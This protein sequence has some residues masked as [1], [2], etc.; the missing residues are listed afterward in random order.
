MRRYI[1]LEVLKGC[2]EMIRFCWVWRLKNLEWFAVLHY[3]Y[4]YFHITGSNKLNFLIFIRQA[5]PNTLLR[6]TSSHFR[7]Y[8]R[9]VSSNPAASFH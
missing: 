1:Y 2:L 4:R 6:T 5:M 9:D 8:L 7:F 3:L